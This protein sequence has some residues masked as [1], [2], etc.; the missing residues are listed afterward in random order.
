MGKAR[1]L[2]LVVLLGLALFATACGSSDTANKA[3]NASSDGRGQKPA[4]ESE[5]PVGACAERTLPETVRLAYKETT[6][7]ETAKFAFEGTATGLP[8]ASGGPATM[9]YT[10]QGAMDYPNRA[11]VM[12]MRMPMF[13]E[14]EVRSL[15]SVMY[16]RFP[17]ELSGQMLGGK[18][19]AKMDLDKV[20]REQYGT[21]FSE[22]Q[23]ASASPEEQLGYLRGASDSVKKLGEEPVRGVPTTHYRAVVDMEKAAAAEKDPRVR[24]AY[25]KMEE[26]IGTTELPMDVWLDEK[27]R[28]R[29]MQMTMPLANAASGGD[30][31]KDARMTMVYEYYDFGAP[32]RVLPPPAAQTID[33][34]DMAVQQQ[35]R[36]S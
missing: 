22:M 21:S 28:V 4:S 17:E 19:W 15:G 23:G 5:S 3:D 26:Q 2:L 16:M 35:A 14:M 7:A 12:T 1:T 6:A 18:P 20:S 13:G 27:D 30:A 9:R 10:G 33:V 24:Q 31:V 8:N 25:E 32:V 34:T 36:A 29:R 11:A